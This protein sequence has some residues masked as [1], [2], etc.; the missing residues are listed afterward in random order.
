MERFPIVSEPFDGR[1]RSLCELLHWPRF[2]SFA[3][4]SVDPGRGY[5]TVGSQEDPSL[6]LANTL[7]NTG[8]VARSAVVVEPLDAGGYHTD[9]FTSVRGSVPRGGERLTRWGQQRT[10]RSRGR[11]SSAP[12]NFQLSPTQAKRGSNPSQPQCP[13][14]C[15]RLMTVRR[16]PWAWQEGTR[17]L[18]GGF[19]P[20]ESRQRSQAAPAAG[21]TSRARCS[22]CWAD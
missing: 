12:T 15:D 7:T 20:F 13:S 3:V 1:C 5:H 14:V 2:S 11:D 9:R 4:F 22:P 18:H 8:R 16:C 6:M 19:T 17:Q 21:Q 10:E